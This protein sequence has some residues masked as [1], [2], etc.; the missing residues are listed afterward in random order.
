MCGLELCFRRKIKLATLTK[1][2]IL[3]LRN[4]LISPIGYNIYWTAARKTGQI[5]LTFGEFVFL[6]MLFRLIT[7]TSCANHIYFSIITFYESFIF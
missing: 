2:P 6:F 4:T 3:A 5:C 7:H 1:S